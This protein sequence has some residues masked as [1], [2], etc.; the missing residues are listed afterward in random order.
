MPVARAAPNVREPITLPKPDASVQDLFSCVHQWLKEIPRVLS[1]GKSV[2]GD[3]RKR[4]QELAAAADAAVHQLESA[5]A[6]ADRTILD[7][8]VHESDVRDVVQDVMREELAKFREELVQRPPLSYAAAAS[9][10]GRKSAPIKTPVSRPAIVLKTSGPESKSSKDVL[11]EWK[12]RVSFK[13]ASFGPRRVQPISNGC[14]RVEFDCVQQRDE[15]LGRL[16]SVPSLKAEPARRQRPLVVLK[17]ISR[18]V[19]EADVVGLVRRQNPSVKCLDADVR[20]RFVRR[21][22]KDELFNCVLEVSPDVRVQLLELGRVSIDHQRVHVSDF[23]SLV[24]CFKCLG[25]GHTRAKCASDVQRCSH[26]ASA[27]HDFASCPD[28]ADAGKLKCHNCSVSGRKSDVRHSGTS[29]KHCPAI[30]AMEKRL[31]SRTDYGC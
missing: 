16:A 31:A 28:K 15:T 11:D 8:G 25:F 19:Q 13:D 3:A 22:R 26:C 18:D 12:K 10:S 6:D 24:Q 20:V 9:A 29:G 1:E 7:A 4:V 30:K 17:G 2:T 14:V 21:N 23:S 5:S 27:G